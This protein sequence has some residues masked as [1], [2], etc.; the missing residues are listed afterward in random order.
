[1]GDLLGR[2]LYDEL[3]LPEG[4]NGQT[5]PQNTAQDTTVLSNQEQERQRQQQGFNDCAR[6]AI[7]TLRRAEY[8]AIGKIAV[9]TFFTALTAGVGAE[10]GAANAAAVAGAR[11]VW[12]RIVGYSARYRLGQALAVGSSVIGIFTG[13]TAYNGFIDS[14]RNHAQLDQALAGCR[15]QFPQA[16]HSTL[17]V[18]VTTYWEVERMKERKNENSLGHFF[19][20]LMTDDLRFRRA[21]FR[22]PLSTAIGSFALNW[23]IL[24]KGLK[25]SLG[26]SAFIFLLLCFTGLVYEAAKRRNLR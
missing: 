4:L 14:S 6:S 25:E 18:F 20:F 8:K 26:I 17:G 23:L 1:L 13:A 11:S 22:L 21:V 2:T 7:R 3:L 12:A 16:N 19:K 10:A 9:G 5:T 15:S 24:G